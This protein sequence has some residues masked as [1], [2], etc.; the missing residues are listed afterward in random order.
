MSQTSSTT[1]KAKS[2]YSGQSST[3]GF[4]AGASGVDDNPPSYEDYMGEEYPDSRGRWYP[5]PDATAEL[6]G[7]HTTYAP[8]SEEEVNHR[9]HS[10][11]YRGKNSSFPKSTKV[12]DPEADWTK[13]AAPGKR[14]EGEPPVFSGSSSVASSSRSS[15]SNRGNRSRQNGFRALPSGDPELGDTASFRAGWGSADI[16]ALINNSDGHTSRLSRSSS[17]SSSSSRG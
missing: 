11:S 16:T 14:G 7:N 9:P 2:R 8:P 17:R 10:S 15:R 4:H 6:G 12:K 13:A 3:G 5:K 1:S